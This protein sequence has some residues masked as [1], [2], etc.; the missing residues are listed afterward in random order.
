MNKWYFDELNDLLFV[1]IGG[2]SRAALWWFDR[3]V[4]DGTV[5]G[6]AT[7][8]QGAGRGIRHI[9]TGR[10]QNYA[11]GIALGPHRHGDRLPPGWSADDR[12][13]GHPAS[14]PP[15][16]SCRWSVRSSS[17]SCRATTCGSI[18]WT[19]LAIA[20]IVF[21]SVALLVLR[22]QCRAGRASSSRSRPPGSRSSGSS[23]TLGVD[24]ISLVAGP[25]HDDAHV[26]QHPGQLQADP[27]RVKE[28]MISFLVLEVGMLGV[29]L[30]LDLVPLLRLLGDRAR[31]DVPDHRHLGRAPTASTRRSSSCC[32]PWSARC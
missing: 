4:V 7:L 22:L 20:F 19:A 2:G 26:D 6:I 11:L 9:Q 8:T 31:P 3:N 25:A 10:V 15:S 17:P 29:F 13:R 27:E 30:A 28:Y 21:G 1:R 12:P 24:G 16:S 14:S 32:T 23:T 18:R 5:N